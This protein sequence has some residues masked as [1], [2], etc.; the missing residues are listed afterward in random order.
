[1]YI[2]SKQQYLMEMDKIE[3][4]K[5]GPYV[6]GQY[7]TGPPLMFKDDYRLP[8]PIKQKQQKIMMY[9]GAI[10]VFIIFVV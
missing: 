6:T 1:M 7:M 2:D 3:K 5:S 4:S 8:D 10:A 9:V